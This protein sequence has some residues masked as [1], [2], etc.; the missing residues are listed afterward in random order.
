MFLQHEEILKVS[1]LHKI[2]IY[3]RK[4]GWEKLKLDV[5]YDAFRKEEGK[6]ELINRILEAIWEPFC[7][8]HPVMTYP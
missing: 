7:G 3:L 6:Y 2:S 8:E 1:S 4:S 5:S